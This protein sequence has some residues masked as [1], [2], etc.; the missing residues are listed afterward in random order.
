VSSA[1]AERL[2]GLLRDR[3]RFWPAHPVPSV[4]IDDVEFQS[5]RYW[6]GPTWVNI[7]WI[8]V[9][10]LRAYGAAELARELVQ[11]TIALVEGGGFAE[12]FSPL[13]GEGYGADDFSWTAALTIDLLASEAGATSAAP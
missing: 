1:K 5:T 8:V 7:N 2:I 12:Y 4:P 10:C 9:E 3:N 6:K 11:Q 13:T